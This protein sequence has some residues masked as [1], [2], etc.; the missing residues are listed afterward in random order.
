MASDEKNGRT[1]R[2][3]GA[4]EATR[5]FGD[6]LSMPYVPF[7]LTRLNASLSQMGVFQAL[8]SLLP[9]LLQLPWGY[10]SDRLGR[11]VPFIVAG[12]VLASMTLVFAAFATDVML[13][14]VIFSLNAIAL[15]IMIPT[16]SALQGDKI[17]H[18][19]RGKGL[20]KILNFALVA[21]ILGNIVVLV[22]FHFYPSTDVDVYKTLFLVGAA[23]GLASIVFV[24]PIKDSNVGRHKLK[25]LTWSKLSREFRFLVKAQVTYNFFMSFAWPVFYI[26]M[27][28]VLKASNTE[29]A[30][31]TLIGVV[32]TIAFQ[33]LVGK[34]IDRAGP[35]GLII[36]S[37]F[38][39]VIVPFAYAFANAMWQIYILN[40]VLGVGM[41]IINVAFTAFI[42][43]V[44]TE[45]TKAEYFSYHNLMVGV[46][47]FVGALIGG[48]LANYLQNI[49]PLATA[50]LIVYFI[51]GFGRL[52]A[53]NMYFGLGD[54]K[55]Y[56]TTTR[57]I[58]NEYI[59]R[60]RIFLY[61]Q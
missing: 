56:P 59:T 46:A 17:K 29:I 53:A 43:D 13:L 16:T 45:E 61:R 47:G 42:L 1:I 19:E 32:A 50:L 3:I 30:I 60:I 18:G 49:W 54:S 24:L 9:N 15:S 6:N 41:A 20:S 44:S 14:I 52:A 37:R 33:P 57:Q 25:F 31:S 35:V 55:R 8:Q 51:S 58:A 40:L 21:G 10:I 48:Y 38:V 2:L 23:F 4:R 7:Y 26:T 5:S 28:Y 12:A 34:V 22:Y 27:A 11:R 36:V 39:F